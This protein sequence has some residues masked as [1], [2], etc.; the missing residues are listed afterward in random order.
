MD[1]TRQIII[2][3]SEVPLRKAKLKQAYK[4]GKNLFHLVWFG[5]IIH[6]AN[7]FSYNV[8]GRNFVDNYISKLYK[9][10]IVRLKYQHFQTIPLLLLKMF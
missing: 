9:I 4:N 2:Q 1:H 8:Q 7:S 6:D 10:Y 5:Q 3:P